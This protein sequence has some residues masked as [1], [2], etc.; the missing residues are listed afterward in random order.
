MLLKHIELKFGSSANARAARGKPMS[1]LPLIFHLS[2]LGPVVRQVLKFCVRDCLVQSEGFEFPLSDGRLN[3]FG[4]L[5]QILLIM[6][7]FS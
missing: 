6:H 1:Q 3:L 4:H 5:L 7:N 2:H